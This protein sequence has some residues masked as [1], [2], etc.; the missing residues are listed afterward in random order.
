MQKRSIGEHG[1]GG[2]EN[3][4]RVQVWVGGRSFVFCH[5]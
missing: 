4:G 5:F 3:G 2:R 1:V